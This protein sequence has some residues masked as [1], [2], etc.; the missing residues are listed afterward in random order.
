MEEEERRVD[1]KVSKPN[2]IFRAKDKKMDE[3]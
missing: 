3:S 2:E 1:M